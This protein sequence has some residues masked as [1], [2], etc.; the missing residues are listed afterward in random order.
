[1]LGFVGNTGDAFTTEPHLH[2]EVHPNGLLYLGYDGAVDPTT[3]LARWE[4]LDRVQAPPP[5]GLPSSAG[6]GQGAVSD[7]RRLLAL[8]PLERPARPADREPHSTA[9]R[10]AAPLQPASSPGSGSHGWGALAAALVLLGTA[11]VAV[12]IA[13]RNGRSS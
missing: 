4:R 11:S 2:F 12:G 7:F 5:V 10:E 8:R 6:R 1:V 13:A 3:Y 9:R